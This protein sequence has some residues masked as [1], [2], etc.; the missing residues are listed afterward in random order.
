MQMKWVLY[1][2]NNKKKSYIMNTSIKYSGVNTYKESSSNQAANSTITIFDI[3]INNDTMSEAVDWVVSKS[4]GQKKVVAQFVNADCLNKAYCDKEYRSTL[5][6]AQH[7]FAD[8]SGIALAGK[9]TQQ[10][11]VDNVNGTD[12]FPL[13]CEKSQETGMRIFLLGARPNIAKRARQNMH[14]Q[15]PGAKIVGVHN[16]YF[17]EDDTDAVIEKINVSK[18]DV[19]LV[20]MGAPTQELWIDQHHKKIN[21]K[22]CIGVGGLFDFYSG[23]ISRAPLWLRTLGCEWTWRLLQEPSRMWQRYLIGNFVFVLR[24]LKQNYLGVTHA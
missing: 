2:N 9:I 22:V 21:A 4:L 14:R 3:N 13:L 12:L 6:K 10:K 24:V 16:G 1:K 7:I 5:S 18:A 23:R 19:L 11:V 17:D 15:Y 20:A 8:G